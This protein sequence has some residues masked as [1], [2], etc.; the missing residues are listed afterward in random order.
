M[1][2]TDKN[3]VER[4]EE[5]GKNDDGGASKI[6]ETK[7][8]TS[9]RITWQRKEDRNDR[10]KMIHQ[11]VRL[12]RTKKPNAPASWLKKL[13]DMARRLEDTLYRHAKS[14]EEYMNAKTLKVRLQ[15]VARRMGA[16]VKQR[17]AQ[18]QLLEQQK[19]TAGANTAAKATSKIPDPAN[20]IK[21][22]QTTEQ[23]STTTRDSSVEEP[24]QKRMIVDLG[25]INQAAVAPP[26]VKKE[27]T[28]TKSN[29]TKGK[30]SSLPA[31]SLTSCLTK[32]D[33]EKR[34]RR[35]HLLRQQQQRLLLLRHASK[36][37]AEN[38]KQTKLCPKM[39]WLWKH[40]A[41]C[42]DKQCQVSHCVSSRYVLTHYHQCKDKKCQVC[43]PVRVW[44]SSARFFFH[45]EASLMSSVSSL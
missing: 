20:N 38:C 5:E 39:K 19:N 17:Q 12:L 37:Q 9:S 13:P 8:S 27:P 10:I 35:Q 29:G 15:D 40:I 23:I 16:R 25:A 36:C 30:N 18:E 31:S 22:E 26:P 21:S 4:N 2:S 14:K 34:K 43:A 44:C 3:G 7:S 33:L 45:Y 28:T 41:Q 24:Q 1:S 42:K 11:I 32:E 6:A